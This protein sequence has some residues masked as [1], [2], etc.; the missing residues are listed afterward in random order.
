M[1]REMGM[2]N[3]E[4]DTLHMVYKEWDSTTKHILS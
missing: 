4:S 3:N 2:D 1:K